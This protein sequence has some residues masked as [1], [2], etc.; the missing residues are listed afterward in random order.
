M[1][2]KYLDENKSIVFVVSNDILIS[3]VQTALD[4]I[5]TVSY[6]TECNKVVINKKNV[7]D[8]FWVLSNCRAGEILQKFMNYN[9][10][11]AIIGDYTNLESKPLRDFIIECNRGNDIFFVENVDI[12]VEKVSK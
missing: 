7:C 5:A 4:F 12:A 6:D 2:Y 8:E 1:E 9:F 3:D 10:K 11:I